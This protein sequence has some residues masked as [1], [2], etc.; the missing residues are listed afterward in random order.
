MN[1]GSQGIR[2]IAFLILAFAVL[3]LS[4]SLS[5]LQGKQPNPSLTALYESVQGT[6]T[7]N[8]LEGD[9]SSEGIATA[10]ARATSTKLVI[11]AIQTE[12]AS[13]RSEGVLAAAT[14]AAPIVAELQVYGLDPANGRVGWIHDPLTLEVEGYQQMDFANDHMQV[15][16]GDFVLA[17]DIT[18]DTQYGTN[19]CGF[20]FRSNGDQNKPSQYMVIASRIGS[21]RVVY[22]AVKDGELNNLHDFYPKDEDRSFEWEN[23]STNRVAIVARGTLIEIFTN[24]VKIGEVV[25]TDPPEP[26]QPPPAPLKPLDENNTA[27]MDSYL[28]QMEEYQE[29]LE[30]LQSNYQIALQNNSDEPAIFD[31]GFLGM[32]ILSESGRTSCS[33]SDTWLWLIEN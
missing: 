11:E 9:S 18:W 13:G 10:Q 19:G 12:S 24:N 3:S 5:S 16:A 23:G 27:A 26:F 1:N 32:L 8:A 28:N 31:D 17:S 33:F 25:T 30:N 20:M 29:I 4:C 2:W 22:T 15:T 21:G 14:V 6:V 7:A